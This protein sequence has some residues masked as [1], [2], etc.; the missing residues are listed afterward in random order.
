M[1]TLPDAS[2]VAGMGDEVVVF[3]ATAV[4]VGVATLAWW[5]TAV[6]E[7]PRVRAVLLQPVRP[8][9]VVAEQVDEAEA[10]RRQREA[11][12]G[13]EVV[14]AG[15]GRRNDQDQEERTEEQEQA[16]T[17]AEEEAGT[18]SS[19]DI[20][21][22]CL[23][24]APEAETGAE[25]QPTAS[26]TQAEE[27]AP[28]TED[29]AGSGITIKL[30]FLNDSQREVRA[31]PTE[32]LGR[33]KRRNFAEDLADNK[34]VRLIFNGQMLSGDGQSLSHY[35]LFDNCVVHCLVS[36]GEQAPSGSQAGGSSGASSG[37][38]RAT[39]VD[40]DDN[41]DL[42]HICYPLLGSVLVMLWWCQVVYSHYFSLASSMSLVTLTVLF[43]G[44]I[45]NTYLY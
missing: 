29:A 43:A 15:G 30:K 10:R 21:E 34:T 26:P 33:F 1:T 40:A 6:R 11:G 20:A 17:A 19:A 9:V 2:M 41:L 38:A 22:E 13:A 4:L 5:T 32:S 28:A 8:G 36:R 37:D 18:T 45:A 25:Q 12:G 44:S 14:F 35:G 23:D 24:D 7:R 16:A 39:F 27:A 3:L 31:A 42:S